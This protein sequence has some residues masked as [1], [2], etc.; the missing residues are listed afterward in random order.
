VSD[1]TAEVIYGLTGQTLTTYPP[2]A[3]Q[4]IPSAATCSVYLGE[5]GNDETAEFSPA[6]TVDAATTSIA[7]GELYLVTNAASQSE[8][9]R[10]I[11]IASA[12]YIDLD[13]DL[14]YDYA[15]GATFKGVSLTVTIDATWVAD[16]SKILTP[17][18]PSYRVMWAYTLGSK[19]RRWWTYL[20]LARYASRHG[21]TIHTLRKYYAD[22][23]AEAEALNRGEAFAGLID[24]AWGDVR[25][26][27]VR[28]GVQPEQ[29]RDT[30]TLGKLVVYRTFLLAA[31]K[32][33]LPG[34][35][36]PD[37]VAKEWQS[38]Y[39][40]LYA[41]TVSAVLRLPVDQGT[42]GATTVVPVTQPWFTR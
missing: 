1:R 4:G 14:A 31:R 34:S 39:D 38:E 15:S 18:E 12:D 33:Q 42:Q 11:G 6:V 16:E 17:D 40:R 3:I 22:L 41:S 29:V 7:L 23:P 36:D 19:S 26:D 28:G 13:A 32:G 8:L 5:R 9:V 37:T 35:R 24:A 27:L 25:S 30:E 20:R 2:E 21:V 10:P